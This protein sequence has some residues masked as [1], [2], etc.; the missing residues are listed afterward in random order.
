MQC[1]GT[2]DPTILPEINTFISLWHDEQQRIDVEYTLK[3]TNLV[4]GLIKELNNVINFIPNNSPELERIPIYKKVC[5][6]KKMKLICHSFDI[7]R[8]SMNLKIH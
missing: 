5:I 6:L 4:L 7:F 2:P 8:R 3:Q 1:D